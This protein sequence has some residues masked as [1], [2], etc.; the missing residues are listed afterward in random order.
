M[1]QHIKC[2][3]ELHKHVDISF[4]LIGRNDVQG[5]SL[6][7]MA[8]VDFLAPIKTA[9]KSQ[10]ITA[11]AAAKTMIETGSGIILM[12]SA[13][14]AK[15]PFENTG[16]FG[17]ACSAIEALSRQLA[18]ELGNHNIRVVCLRSAGSPDAEGVAEV[19]EVHA[20]I[21]K[22]SKEEFASQ[23]AEKT[24]LKHL[25]NLNEIANVAAIMASDKTTSIKAAIINVTCG[26]LAD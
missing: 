25:P 19:F 7:S 23:F 2:I 3:V 11:T 8:T 26:E 18:V 5:F 1:E 21:L 14:A 20:G 6:I 12:L 4:N 17:V 10:F 24:M 22:I 13:N 16:G 15:K 9:I